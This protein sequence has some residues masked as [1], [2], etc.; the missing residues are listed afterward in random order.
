MILETDSRGV[1]L[2]TPHDND[3]AAR[4]RGMT[5][6]RAAFVTPN[7]SSP[8]RFSYTWLHTPEVGHTRHGKQAWPISV[9]GAE[10]GDW[11]EFQYTD[12]AMRKHDYRRRIVRTAWKVTN[13]AVG[14][15][16]LT[17][18]ADESQW[19]DAPVEHDCPF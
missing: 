15:I 18:F 19:D 11:I 2:S 6:V 17:P 3:P 16:E 7:P 13:V 5:R 1:L 9:R 10:V 8:G 4:R 12:H 14:A